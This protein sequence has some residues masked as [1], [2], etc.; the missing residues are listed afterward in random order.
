LSPWHDAESASSPLRVDAVSEQLTSALA[1]DGYLVDRAVGQSHFRCDLAVR[2]PGDSNYRLGV[3]VDTASYYEQSDILERDVMRPRLL[4]NFGWNVCQVFAKDWYLERERVVERLLRILAGE[5]EANV[6][7]GS[8]DELEQHGAITSSTYGN[9][10]GEQ[11]DIPSIDR[12]GAIDMLSQVGDVSMSDVVTSDAAVAT[13]PLSRATTY[14]EFNDGK[15]HKFW[16]ITLN[17]NSHSVRFGRIGTNGQ[18]IAKT[19]STEQQAKAD[20]ERL[21]R[22]KLAKGYYK[23]K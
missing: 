13:A 14:L 5:K 18:E 16:E 6:D 19:F 3:L 22:Q 15:S 8:S 20:C 12:L 9:D 21:I 1:A 10:A 11:M 17:S 2:R 23:D 4:R 7:A